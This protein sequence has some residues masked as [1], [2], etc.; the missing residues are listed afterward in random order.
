MSG[1]AG[2]APPSP[3]VVRVAV[4]AEGG[5]NAPDAIL[6]GV[7]AVASAL[8]QVVLVGR[9]QSLAPLRGTP[10]V[11]LV[12]T[13]DVIGAGDEP[14]RSVRAK[15]EASMVVAAR[16]VG[17]GRADAVFS[18]GNTG[19]FVAASMLTVR[20]I[21]G[22]RRPAISIILPSRPRPTLLLDAGAN[23]EV[24]PAHLL[25]FAHMGQ[26]FAREV[27]GTASP[28]VGLLSI[29]EEPGKGTPLVV[30]AHRLLAEDPEVRFFGNVEGRDLLNSTVDVIVTD[31]FTGNI[32]LKCAEGVA[33]SVLLRLKEAVAS[34]ARA[35][36]GG[37]LLRPDLL[38]VRA[39][40]DP[41]EYGGQHLLGM[42][43]PVLIGHG[44]SG[45][46]GVEN[47]L[48]YAARAVESGLVEAITERLGRGG[49]EAADAGRSR[50]PRPSA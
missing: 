35:R 27:L 48:R 34:S 7:G 36:V 15:P 50:P 8:L 9:P 24:Q 30:E 31:G 47:A 38:R 13:P 1:Q 11:E 12:E 21:R 43:R 5:D 6:R 37:L 20:R 33:R 17:E 22:V 44:S 29:G 3:R 18:A 45:A 26:A 16:L 19:A 49:A 41:E 32:V 23:A 40:M 39:A 2:P 25:Q 4:D 42:S 14:A 10:N 46:R 28:S